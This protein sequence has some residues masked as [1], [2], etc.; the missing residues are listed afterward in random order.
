MS[1]QSM[2]AAS[3][4]AKSTSEDL[5]MTT[6]SYGD[7]SIDK[8]AAAYS[9]QAHGP[10]TKSPA[11][12]GEVCEG[13]IYQVL[14]SSGKSLFD[15]PV[16]GNKEKD[17]FAR[18]VTKAQAAWDLAAAMRTKVGYSTPAADWM[19]PTYPEVTTMTSS[20][21]LSIDLS[22]LHLTREVLDFTVVLN[23]KGNPNPASQKLIDRARSL[24]NAA[25][26]RAGMQI[27]FANLPTAPVAPSYDHGAIN[28]DRV[29][30]KWSRTVRR[31]MNRSLFTL[32]AVLGLVSRRR[33]KVTTKVGTGFGTPSIASVTGIKTMNNSRRINAAIAR[34]ARVKR[35]RRNSKSRKVALTSQQRAANRAARATKAANKAARR[36]A[37][38]A[39]LAARQSAVV[40]KSGVVTRAAKC[41]QL[42]GDHNGVV[43]S[44]GTEVP[45]LR[46]A[47]LR[48][49]RFAKI[50]RDNLSPAVRFRRQAAENSRKFQRDCRYAAGRA[51]TRGMTEV[52]FREVVPVTPPVLKEREVGPAP[53]VNDPIAPFLAEA[54]VRMA[55]AKAAYGAG[56]LQMC[57]HL[58]AAAEVK[59]I[60]N[61]V[62]ISKKAEGQRSPGLLGAKSVGAAVNGFN[63]DS[64]EVD[65]VPLLKSETNSSSFVTPQSGE[66]GLPMIDKVE[67]VFGNNITKAISVHNN[68]HSQEPLGYAMGIAM[69]YVSEEGDL[70][71]GNINLP[72][73]NNFSY[74]A[75][76][77]LGEPLYSDNKTLNFSSL[78]TPSKEHPVISVRA[79][80]QG[81]AG[82]RQSMFYMSNNWHRPNLLLRGKPEVQ[83]NLLFPGAD[84]VVKPS[85]VVEGKTVKDRLGEELL[86][87]RIAFHEAIVSGS[88]L[89]DEFGN[90][91]ESFG[92]LDLQVG[93]NIIFFVA[94]VG[95]YMGLDNSRQLLFNVH[96]E[97]GNVVG[98]EG[99]V[100]GAF[101]H[102]NGALYGK[103]LAYTR[104]ITNK[105]SL[106]KVNNLAGISGVSD[107]SSVDGAGAGLVFNKDITK[108]L[109]ELFFAGSPLIEPKQGTF[110][111][112]NIR[113]LNFP[114]EDAK[115][116]MNMLDMNPGNARAFNAGVNVKPAVDKTVYKKQRVVTTEAEAAEPVQEVTNAAPVVA[117][118]DVVETP[119]AAPVVELGGDKVENVTAAPVVELGENNPNDPVIEA[120]AVETPVDSYASQ[121]ANYNKAVSTRWVTKQFAKVDIESF[122]FGKPWAESAQVIGL[123]DKNVI[124][125]ADAKHLGAFAVQR[126]LAAVTGS[127]LFEAIEFSGYLWTVKQVEDII[128]ILL[129]YQLTPKGKEKLAQWHTD[130]EGNQVLA[131]YGLR[132]TF[133]D[134]I[135]V[136]DRR[137]RLFKN[138]LE[139]VY[140]DEGEGR[141]FS[142]TSCIN[143]VG[144]FL[145]LLYLG[146]LPLYST[147]TLD[148]VERI[149]ANLNSLI[150]ISPDLFPMTSDEIRDD[151]AM[152]LWAEASAW[153][154]IGKDL[155]A[156][157]RGFK[158]V[159][160]K[161][162][163]LNCA[164]AMAK[165]L[166]K[167]YTVLNKSVK[168]SA[169][170][171]AEQFITHALKNWSLVSSFNKGC[172][173]SATGFFT[174][175]ACLQETAPMVYRQLVDEVNAQCLA[176]HK[177]SLESLA[178]LLKVSVNALMA[179]LIVNN[180]QKTSK[181]TKRILLRAPNT[182]PSGNVV[183]LEGRPALAKLLADSHGI[184]PTWTKWQHR[185]HPDFYSV[186]TG[187]KLSY[188]K[189]HAEGTLLKVA[190]ALTGVGPAGE[191]VFIGKP[192]R[193]PTGFNNKISQAEFILAERCVDPE[194]KSVKVGV[195]KK[196]ALCPIT[197]D[198]PGCVLNGME[199]TTETRIIGDTSYVY[200]VPKEAIFVEGDGVSTICG[201]LT[202]NKDAPVLPVQHEKRNGGGILEWV[203]YHIAPPLT[204]E[205]ELELEWSVTWNEAWPKIRSVI[206]KSQILAAKEA[207]VVN[208]L[209]PK[210]NTS[211]VDIVYLNDAVKADT[212]VSMVGTIGAT[213]VYNPDTTDAKF[214]AM[215]QLA[216]DINEEVEGRRHLDYLV[217]DSTAVA[218]NPKYR[219]LFGMFRDYFL[220]TMWTNWQQLDHGDFGQGMLQLYEDLVALGKWHELTGN[221]LNF[222][223][224]AGFA[225]KD[226]K[227]L[228]DIR[229]FVDTSLIEP[230]TNIFVFAFKNG[231]VSSIKQ[232]CISLVG[233]DNTPIYDVVMY[234]RSTNKEG[235]NNNPAGQMDVNIRSVKR[236]T[237]AAGINTNGFVDTL[238]ARQAESGKQVSMMHAKFLN[239]ML[240]SKLSTAIPAATVIK[241]GT[242][243]TEENNLVPVFKADPVA[244]ATVKQLLANI[245]MQSQNHFGEICSVF[246]NHI[247]QIDSPRDE[248]IVEELNGEQQ[249]V[250]VTRSVEVWTPFL[251]NLNGLTAENNS[252]NTVSGFFRDYLLAAINGKQ[253]KLFSQKLIG[254]LDSFARSESVRKFI[255]GDQTVGGK[256]MAMPSCPTSVLLLTE[257]SDQWK[258]VA[259][260]VRVHGV[261]LRNVPS[262]DEYKEH[263]EAV[264]DVLKDRAEVFNHETRSPLADGPIVR[265]VKLPASG[266][267][268]KGFYYS[269]TELYQQSYENNEPVG[270]PQFVKPYPYTRGIGTVAHTGMNKG[271][272]DGDPTVGVILVWLDPVEKQALRVLLTTFNFAWT[273]CEDSVGGK[274]K[275][276]ERGLYLGDHLAA[277][278]A[279][280]KL[281]VY[282]QSNWLALNAKPVFDEAD[283]EKVIGHELVGVGLI[284]RFLFNRNNFRA[285]IMQQTFVGA[286][287][288]VYRI[289]EALFDL[290]N[291]CPSAEFKLPA[292]LQWCRNKDAAEVVKAVTELY[293]IILGAT[294][295]DGW[296]LWQQYYLPVT[297][298]K[299]PRLDYIEA[300]SLPAANPQLAALEQNA[301]YAA[302]RNKRVAGLKSL[303]DDMGANSKYADQVLY[304]LWYCS[305]LAKVVKSEA[306]I[307]I[308]TEA[309]EKRNFE[310]LLMAAYMSV[311][312]GRAKWAGYKSVAANQTTWTGYNLG[313]GAL[314][315]PSVSDKKKARQQDMT[316][317]VSILINKPS[318]ADFFSLWASR[319]H[320]MTILSQLTSAEVLG[321]LIAGNLEVTDNGTVT[322]INK[323]YTLAEQTLQYYQD[324]LTKRVGDIVIPEVIIDELMP[325]DDDAPAPYDYDE[326]FVVY[327]DEDD[328]SYLDD[329]PD[330]DDGYPGPD[331]D[332][333]GGSGVDDL[334][335][336][337]PDL[338]SGHYI[339][340]EET[341]EL[342]NE[343]PP[344]EDSFVE[345]E[346]DSDLNNEP[347]SNEDYA[348]A[349][350]A[351][352]GVVTANDSVAPVEVAEDEPVEVPTAAPVIVV[353]YDDE[354]DL[355]NEPLPDEDY[356]IAQAVLQ[357]KVVEEATPAAPVA[358]RV[359]EAVVTPVTAPAVAGTELQEV[360]AETASLE[361]EI[362]A[363]EAA[364]A[365]QE[366]ED[367]VL[368]EAKAKRDALKSERDAL[369]GKLRN[370]YLAEV[371]GNRTVTPVEPVE[372]V[373]EDKGDDE[374]GGAP[375][376]VRKP[377]P[378]PPTTPPVVA[379]EEPKASATQ[380]SIK[381]EPKEAP[382]IWFNSATTSYLWMSNFFACP[383]NYQGHKYLTAEAAYQLAKCAQPT[384]EQYKEF[385][386]MKGAAAKTAGRKVTMR[387]DWD[388][389]K[390]QVM[391]DV[392]FAKFSDAGLKAKLL[393]TGDT[394]LIHLV[395][396][397]DLYWGRGKDGKGLNRMGE[398]LMQVRKDLHDGKEPAAPAPAN[399]PMDKREPVSSSPVKGEVKFIKHITRNMLQANPNALYVFGDNFERRGLGGQAKEM[400]GE[401][402][403]V[404]IATKHKPSN[405]AEAFF[406]DADFAQ[407]KAE[408]AD[409]LGYL[410]SELESGKDIYFPED[411]IGTG[412]SALP[413]KAPTIWNY[414]VTCLQVNL[415]ITK[416]QPI[417]PPVVAK[418]EPKAAP[419][420]QG[421]APVTTTITPTTPT[422]T[423]LYTGSSAK[424]GQ[425]GW[426]V[427]TEDG[428]VI[429]SGSE[430][431]TTCN[432]MSLKSV[433]E[434]L[435]VAAAGKGK[436]RVHCSNNY[437]LIGALSNSK[438]KANLELWEQVR[439]VWSGIKG[440]TSI[441][442]G[443]LDAAKA[444]AAGMLTQKADRAALNK[445]VMDVNDQHIQQ[446]GW[447][448]TEAKTQLNALY[449]VSSR[450]ELT[451]GQLVEWSQYC[452]VLAEEQAEKAKKHNKKAT[453][454]SN[455]MQVVNI[456]KG[457]TGHYI[458][459]AGKGKKGSALANPYVVGK[460]GTREECCDKYRAWLWDQVNNQNQSVLGELRLLQETR[461]NLV[462]FCAPQKCHGEAIIEC[463]EWLDTQQSKGIA[464]TT[465]NKVST[466]KP[467]EQKRVV[468]PSTNTAVT[469]TAQ[470]TIDRSTVAL[471]V[472]AQHT[473]CQQRF[474]DVAV[475]G[476]DIFLS[477]AP[478]TGKT[479][480]TEQIA[481][482][483]LSLGDK[484]IITATT[485][486]AVMNLGSMFKQGELTALGTVNSVLKL[487]IGF[488][489]KER[490]DR[491]IKAWNWANTLVAKGSSDKR[492]ASLLKSAKNGQKVHFIL[493]EVSMLDAR[494]LWVIVSILRAHNPAI[495]ILLVG[496]GNQLQPVSKKDDPSTPFWKT[497]VFVGCAAT[498]N[499]VIKEF[500]VVNLVTNVRQA[501]DPS[502]K[503]A[504]DHLART[505]EL[506]GVLLERLNG[507]L[508][509]TLKPPSDA[510]CTHIRYNNITVERIN[511]EHTDALQAEKK[512]YKATIQDNTGSFGVPNWV[513]EFSPIGVEME[514]GVGMPIKLRR[515]RKGEND[516]L[517]ASNGSRGIITKLGKSSVW[518]R[519]E[520]D[521]VLEVK[522]ETFEGPNDS[523]GNSKG[524][525]KQLPLHPDYATT[526]HS[527]QG[528]TIK[529]AVVIGI[530]QERR[531]FAKG[532]PVLDEQG[533]V[534]TY[535]CAISDAEWILVACSRVERADQ[536][537]FD[538]E[539]PNIVNLIVSSMGNKDESYFQW[540]EGAALS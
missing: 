163:F 327:S 130:D 285:L 108:A 415:G 161:Y 485:G 450:Q 394:Q 75:W 488:D 117:G 520:N 321:D 68:T 301:D 128:S 339:D 171:M 480:A 231:K 213:L 118:V 458:G 511:K 392:L 266:K 268:F 409:K 91:V 473:P 475:T 370:K 477:G 508:N 178:G 41:A 291:N 8:I 539:D 294:D 486:R 65:M 221:Q 408:F 219:K 167:Q 105:L 379:K 202:D 445:A 148:E 451:S 437:V 528:L 377:N 254:M 281:A 272:S 418:E 397:N 72:I 92:G 232:R 205:K 90:V 122:K 423:N 43:Y 489:E 364:L 472:S 380:E 296:A 519:F 481:R 21:R 513:N 356:A 438:Q 55:E 242:W 34:T 230:T 206:V 93:R 336:T 459:R 7:V 419:A 325:E 69:V 428:T 312:A 263:G 155:G 208:G 50:E 255:S 97:N 24:Y 373:K 200:F 76:S 295:D 156:S 300:F 146:F 495:Q 247:F 471:P 89:T 303:M 440:R 452:E 246:R 276:A 319:S 2:S 274:G 287:Y 77:K 250:R 318:N 54:A 505:N 31:A 431:D 56:D 13:N 220:T 465:T 189:G 359:V 212:M 45:V 510:D 60:A 357:G 494:L 123:G 499:R 176:N 467:Q 526:G 121:L 39:L 53:E 22:G 141:Q 476:K 248:F 396:W 134:G 516:A 81:A 478:G 78:V 186:K 243:V 406:T 536:I 504:L 204:T 49:R 311:E 400:R 279:S 535:K 198:M 439:S 96:M 66:G 469:T 209:N 160:N 470:S 534:K 369:K 4:S 466:K 197:V 509:G 490:K 244:I 149:G 381:G 190:I 12:I 71:H 51:M 447:S 229:C 492:L 119:A 309:G 529:N 140:Y 367:K 16:N 506:S 280:K 33:G 382:A 58:Q 331:E 235:V 378:K 222:L 234:E 442:K 59:P 150:N 157:Y 20:N 187:S 461:P 366:A 335:T 527:C 42:R 216:M 410:R 456:H 502:L 214:E 207:F 443:S 429:T 347:L 491:G 73:R 372:S 507:C 383:L 387:G 386:T 368:A 503:E 102:A 290:V 236:V 371:Y 310:F 14:A 493:D 107:W 193:M 453:Q 322:V 365:K 132:F 388:K 159:G 245:D 30:R 430:S 260:Q 484:V 391:Y 63:A 9:E 203:R 61:S 313:D 196:T 422:I 38:R 124:C 3:V 474:F 353:D 27:S 211:L 401:P 407:A 404:G 468:V 540:L 144:A 308:T 11:A 138:L 183:D 497:P 345:E 111:A 271:D 298:G 19:P 139:V 384:E 172:L 395:T 338:D 329:C 463:I 517:E 217:E 306:P 82:N 483:W 462:C 413:T 165:S 145:R 340:E 170:G 426:A 522:P 265:I 113:N 74:S 432:A 127:E 195:A 47:K 334:N 88:S 514:L 293:E 112:W 393:A 142:G 237:E 537:F 192:E 421:A 224:K 515:N 259:Q 252:H 100:E 57:Y 67:A 417:N 496:D 512:V 324:R 416:F 533:N 286:A 425:G 188:Q 1:N 95:N 403:A 218:A 80:N 277:P 375:V 137:G 184:K 348:I 5:T 330:Y 103:Q 240:S 433:L 251:Y 354:D 175:V 434:A 420:K 390:D 284:E 135:G 241:L 40:M 110:A 99:L 185:V 349:Q 166:A 48:F 94:E 194:S 143:S 152:V 361:S 210:V 351:L 223:T 153:A 350:A 37:Y 449:G 164:G 269:S 258:K 500:T 501:Q 402:N 288:R 316:R 249:S 264:W 225:S 326:E 299:F 518:V 405:T 398:I 109:A 307:V 85:N 297:Q 455:N 315:D 282:S 444:A 239:L 304:C 120:P 35:Q 158:K 136:L 169:A 333:L 289:A 52:K 125:K 181:G 147:S 228:S 337:P 84:G 83:P 6:T 106:Y 283:S 256:I 116:L 530:Y 18:L 448:L 436:Y 179:S 133:V 389:I 531:V 131:I 129:S 343:L 238:M 177:V 270:K 346:E 435:K 341:M 521:V 464:M 98:S 23:Q 302:I 154:P 104:L 332:D 64:N 487:G 267:F 262:W 532:K 15:K 358:P 362:K 257:H 29:A 215:R 457:G 278:K 162:A 233:K 25:P 32:D 376:V 385:G 199:F 261:D 62:K 363:L 17:A 323:G 523:K 275:M 344:E 273:Y 227:F 70:V 36:A 479:Y 26:V 126:Y 86:A 314:N 28:T 424:D 460:D 226:G 191:S 414:L 446:L 114:T 412:L 151:N 342:N 524:T 305:I 253:P 441:F 173:F 115:L 328:L 482:H 399:P 87:T 182:I 411:G 427:C 292:A 101:N 320:T 79:A 317:L 355:N 180:N 525:F 46:A 352:Q 168:L 10:L 454:L 201:V 360:L 174:D 538:I 374:D 44:N 498:V